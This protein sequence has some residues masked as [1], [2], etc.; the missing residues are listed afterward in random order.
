MENLKD[1]LKYYWLEGY[2]F[3]KVSERLRNNQDFNAKDFLAVVTWKSSR[4]K[5]L[6]SNA[7]KNNR[8]ESDCAEKVG[9]FIS[10]IDLKD[11][12]KQKRVLSKFVKNTQFVG[13]P[14]ASA[15]LAVAYPKVFTIID[16]RVKRSLAKLFVSESFKDSMSDK[17][18]TK[19]VKDKLRF[20]ADPASS[21]KAYLEYCE[22][23]RNEAR[24]IK[25]SLRNFDRMLWGYDFYRD[26]KKLAEKIK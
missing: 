26:L 12:E 23:C 6:I 15:F 11:T 8:I 3:K 18:V 22:Y 7:T 16:I 13:L 25:V 17:E 20:S 5:G 21:P 19:I 2:L 9:K 10:S 4:T 24:R 14:M 1:Y